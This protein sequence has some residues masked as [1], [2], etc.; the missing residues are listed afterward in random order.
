MN[1]ID[2]FQ[3]EFEFLSNFYP[4]WVRF[5]SVRFA[6]VEH[7]YQ[8]ARTLDAEGRKQIRYAPTPGQAKRSGRKAPTREDWVEI[9][10]DVM[11]ELLRQKFTDAELQQ[12]LLAT[13]DREIIEGNYWHDTFWGVCT[14]E[15]CPEGQN[16]LG[17]LLMEIRQEL[18]NCSS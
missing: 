11:R 13:G 9:K 18:S 17:R 16:T 5:E 2:S 4:A 3:G 6:T 8:F 10:V 1:S 12:R 7:A 14:C 15:T